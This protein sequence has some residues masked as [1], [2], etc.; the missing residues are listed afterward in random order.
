MFFWRFQRFISGNIIYVNVGN[1]VL[2]TCENTPFKFHFL[3]VRRFIPAPKYS[4]SDVFNDEILLGKSIN[5]NDAIHSIISRVYYHQICPIYYVFLKFDF[6]YR[7]S[8]YYIINKSY[9]SICIV[10]FPFW[11]IKIENTNLSFYN[12][13]L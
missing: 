8:I 1:I 7:L 11:L 3:C 2:Y 12:T 10:I 6:H 13:L 4:I 5:I 9:F